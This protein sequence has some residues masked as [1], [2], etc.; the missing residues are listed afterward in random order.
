[1]SK[2]DSPVTAYVQAY[3]RS[4]EYPHMTF[5]S[6]METLQTCQLMNVINNFYH[7]SVSCMF[8]VDKINYELIPLPQ[9]LEYV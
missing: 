3:D 2:F 8:F 4:V 7:S 5:R 6:P 1:M 9:K